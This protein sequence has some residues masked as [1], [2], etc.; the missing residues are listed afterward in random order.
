MLSKT[1]NFMEE[2]REKLLKEL[3]HHQPIKMLYALGKLEFYQ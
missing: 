3:Y 1:Y 2:N